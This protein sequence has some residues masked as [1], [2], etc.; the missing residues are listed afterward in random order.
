VVGPSGSGKT[1]GL[2][3]PNAAAAT[4]SFVAA[5]PKGELWAETSGRHA[6]AWRFAP[7]E[8]EAS[9]GF[10]WIPLCR[11][12]ALARRLAAAAM[13]LEA[14]PHEEQFWKLADL[15]L[16]AALF[17]HAAAT[18]VPTPATAYALLEQGPSALV[19]HLAA[20]PAPVARSC[21]ALLAEL[22]PET[23]AGIV[24]SVANK[25]AFLQDPTVRRFTSAQLGPPAL[26][27][28]ARQPTAAYWVLHERDVALL[29]P[30][31]SLFFTLLLEQL[32]R[33]RGPVPVTL[34][35]DEFAN[36]G[37]LPEFPTTIAVARGRGLA[38]AL[39]VQALGQL[40]ALYG[41]HGAET[42]RTNCATKV[43]LHGL[44]YDSAEA[45]SR[46][47]GERTVRQEF[48]SRQPRE[49]LVTSYSYA[50]HQTPRRLLTADEVRRLGRDELLV[51]VSNLRPI[52]ARRWFWA[53]PP[54]T[55]AAPRLGAAR[56]LV[57]PDPPLPPASPAAR[58]LAEKLR[59]LDEE[60]A[61]G[62]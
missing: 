6:R 5:D 19:G 22:K 15:Q 55:A 48:R 42:I 50:E 61:A 43:V 34:L 29:Q 24:L 1:R 37:R 7:R 47:L 32:G 60:D 26:D 33:A 54:Q 59:Q 13:Q 56:A 28:L 18:A 25:L 11:D 41:R 23:R 31:A 46:A 45:V 16:C 51:L 62:P 14:D 3:L 12:A 44:D 8:P 27:D 53:E 40:E 52:R 57:P 39:G 4:G 10:N 30:L 20:S 36:V 21:A 2:F 9:C 35:L 38:L 17:G 49:P 58:A